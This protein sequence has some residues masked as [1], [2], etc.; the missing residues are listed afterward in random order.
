MKFLVTAG[1]AVVLALPACTPPRVSVE[2]AMAECTE[3]VR[4]AQRGPQTSGTIGVGVGS[5]GPR[6]SV[7]IG[8]SIPLDRNRDP[9]DIYYDCV[10]KRSGQA[11]T[12][13]LR[14]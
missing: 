6:T 5:G 1:L 4:E 3:R 10:L 2:R 8:V 11:P 7:G 14:L 9:V 13:P 12:E